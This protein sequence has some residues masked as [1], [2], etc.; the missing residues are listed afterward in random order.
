MNYIFTNILGTFILD[1]KMSIV[2]SLLFKTVEEYK[3]KDNTEAKL[4]KKHNPKPLPTEKLLQALLL[5]KDAKYYADFYQKNLELTKEGLKNAVNEDNLIMQAIANINELDKISNTMS[6]RLR[7]WY[8]F[9]YPELS[10]EIED[11]EQYVESVLNKERNQETFGAD[12]SESDIEEMKLLAGRIT[13]LY[14]LRKQ[15][16]LYLEKIM[17]KYCPNLLELAGATI[18]A[19][20]IELGKGLKHLAFLPASTIQLLGA[21]KALF[22][23]LKTGSR[24]PK[25]GIIINHPLIQNAKRDK[26]G[27][28]A[29]MLADKLS[30]CARLDFFKGE[31]KAPDYRKD[32]EGKLA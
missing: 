17:S 31:F 7:E 6:K 3:N 23:H 5:F 9:Y 13:S 27:K 26:K 15:H 10:E 24:S 32:L 28:A 30:L 18:A 29:R 4:Q 16:E 8:S 22:R 1:E 21:E 12:L 19:R 25:H 11:H 20:L 14:A 2:D